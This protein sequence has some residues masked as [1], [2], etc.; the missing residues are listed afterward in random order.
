MAQK[1]LSKIPHIQPLTGID[2][3]KPGFSDFINKTI[4]RYGLAD[5]NLLNAGQK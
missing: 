4:R 2:T 3:V 5:S 1:A